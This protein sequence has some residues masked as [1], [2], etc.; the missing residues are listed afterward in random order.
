M[1]GIFISFE[2]PD[3]AGK[4]TQLRLLAK[5]LEERGQT[6]LCTREPGG[7]A[8]GD[9]IRALL[10]DPAND[11]MTARAEALLYMAARAQHVGELIAPALA[12]GEIVLS[13][14]YAD[15]T[16]VYQGIARKLPQADLLA[17][18]DFAT[19]GLKPQLTILLDCPRHML[20]GRMDERGAKDRIEQEADTFH[21]QVRQ[22][23]L[24]LAGEQPARFRVIDASCSVE[25]VHQAVVNVIE[26]FLNRRGTNED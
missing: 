8:I 21:E 9:A 18:N 2:G 4:T 15:S 26:H 12:R 5:Y 10:L 14:R 1:S 13:D 6:V 19:N 23:F 22:G 7:T 16:I 11:G 25:K 3:G 17:I 24:T 20:C